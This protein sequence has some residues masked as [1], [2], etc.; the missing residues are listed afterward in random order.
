MKALQTALLAARKAAGVLPRDESSAARKGQPAFSY[1][2][3]DAIQEE[4]RHLD[5]AGLLLLAE[6]AEFSDLSATFSWRLIHVESGEHLDYSLTWPLFTD[7]EQVA[8]RVAAAW[9]HCWG[10]LVMQLLALRVAPRVEATTPGIAPWTERD[11]AKVGPMPA[12]A[13]PAKAVVPREPVA[14]ARYSGEHLIELVNWWCA[15]EAEHDDAEGRPVT[16]RTLAHAWAACT[17][18]RVWG[19]MPPL[20]A[21]ERE[22]LFFWLLELK[23]TST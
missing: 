9:S 4:A 1:P 17:G 10:R 11:A 2:S 6:G 22:R 19:D 21:S 8:H 18:E 16:S 15:R 5:A 23:G 3:Q 14:P 20:T 7:M 12:W 13:G